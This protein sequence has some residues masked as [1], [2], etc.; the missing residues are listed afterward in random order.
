MDKSFYENDIDIEFYANRQRDY[1]EI[2]PWDFIDIGVRKDF[3]GENI[4]EA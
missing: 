3:Y 1:D 2:L 4:I